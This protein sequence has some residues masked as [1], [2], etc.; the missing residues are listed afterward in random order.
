[1]SRVIVYDIMPELF[2][3]LCYSLF[4]IVIYFLYFMLV[5]SIYCIVVSLLLFNPSIDKPS[6]C[7]MS[8]APHASISS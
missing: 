6:I 7:N 4:V 2:N 3:T 5:L 8:L 1:M